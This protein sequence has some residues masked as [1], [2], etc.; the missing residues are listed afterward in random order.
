M[1]T[2]GV[3]LAGSGHADG[4]EIT[5]AVLTLLAID[6]HNARPI[7]MAPNINQHHVINHL[8]K[9]EDQSAMPRNI[10]IE[11]A[12]IARGK[13]E[14][15]INVDHKSLDALVLPGGFG[16]AKNLCNFAFAGACAE[17]IPSVK[18]LL[19]QMYENKKPIGGICISPA[20]LSI[21]FGHLGVEVTVGN[22]VDT[23]SLIEKMGAKHVIKKVTE[24]HID[25]KMRIV[26]TPAYMYGD[27]KIGELETGIDAC[28]KGVIDLCQTPLS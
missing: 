22:D 10:L 26:T 7:I 16:V 24:A 5:E 17:V 13:I 9:K 25:R 1:K 23:I 11:A 15:I 27:S 19:L 8:M 6:K 2:I 3:I 12:R 4:S 14:D 18:K 28:I 21:V 20:V